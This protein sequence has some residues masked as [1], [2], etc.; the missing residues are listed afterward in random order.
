[1]S[2]EALIKGLTEALVENTEQLKMV[3]AGREAAI[4]KLT[5]NDA[6]GAPA[7]KP[8]A[9]AKK[10]E[11][12]AA[13]EPAAA[14]PAAEP[15][16]DAGPKYNWNPDLS[17]DGLR[18]LAQ[19]L[20]AKSASEK[21]REAEILGSFKSVLQE[22]GTPKFVG[23]DSTLDEDGKRKGAFYITRFINDM[24]VDFNADYNFGE[25]P[26]TQAVEPEAAAADEDFGIG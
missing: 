17:D 3:N 6:G 13:A 4:E 23:A 10:D 25:D 22:L 21:D 9:S 19:K 26:L 16:A 8:R 5:T 2:I 12:P 14:E 11:A 24:P 20:V 15:A 1:M 7:R 18:A